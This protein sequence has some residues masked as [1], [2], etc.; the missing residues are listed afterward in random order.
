M[1]HMSLLRA[2]V[3]N[4]D[5]RFPR[6]DMKVCYNFGAADEPEWFINEILGH[7]WVDSTGLELQVHWTLGNV[8]WEPLAS[9]KELAALDEYLELRRVKRPRDL[10]RKTH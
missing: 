8:M 6:R 2:H 1:F 9:C 5:A 7:C 10:P 3:P 4:D